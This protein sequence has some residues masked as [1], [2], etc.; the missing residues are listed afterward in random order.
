MRSITA[1][2]HDGCEYENKFTNDEAYV[3]EINGESRYP[4]EYYNVYCNHPAY[5]KAVKL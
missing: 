5:I 1:Y 2:H 4:Y 3:I